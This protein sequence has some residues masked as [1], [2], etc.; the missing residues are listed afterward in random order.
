MG[1]IGSGSGTSFPGALDTNAVPEVASDYVRLAWGTDVE[2][3]IAAIEAELGV[4]P[5]GPSAT[6]VARLNMLSNATGGGVPRGLAAA[7]PAASAG[8]LYL[9]TDTGVIEY[10]T[11][12]EWVPILAG[13]M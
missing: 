2:A 10:S 5:A 8:V 12:S 11:G 7:R 4:D 1:E 6:V 13:G 9:S 3:C